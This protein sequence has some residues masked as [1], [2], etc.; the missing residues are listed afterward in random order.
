[1]SIDTRNKTYAVLLLGPTENIFQAEENLARVHDWDI[2]TRASFHEHTD[3]LDRMD[4]LVNTAD[5]VV[6]LGP[7][8]PSAIDQ[9]FLLVA[10]HLG[11]DVMSY[12]EAINLLEVDTEM[13]CE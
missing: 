7:L 1:M 12:D 13:D 6:Y 10:L 4:F 11:L 8:V 2:M 5:A 9:A 3:I